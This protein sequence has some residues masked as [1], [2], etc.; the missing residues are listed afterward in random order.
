MNNYN[1][2][3]LG[4]QNFLFLELLPLKLLNWHVS[5]P[6][7]KYSFKEDS[8]ISLNFARLYYYNIYCLIKFIASLATYY[9]N[10]ILQEILKRLFVK[11][12]TIEILWCPLV[13]RFTMDYETCA[14]WADLFQLGYASIVCIVLITMKFIDN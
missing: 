10:V 1:Y 11:F 6:P 7:F 5:F 13:N 2:Q 3:Y 4:F 9:L 14:C 8:I 12:K